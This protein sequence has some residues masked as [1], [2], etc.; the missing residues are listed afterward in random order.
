MGM[1]RRLQRAGEDLSLA[2]SRLASERR[3][4]AASVSSLEATLKKLR[5]EHMVARVCNVCKYD[6]VT[7]VNSHRSTMIT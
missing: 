5:D 3:E 6:S 4:R 7:S 1:V 2:E